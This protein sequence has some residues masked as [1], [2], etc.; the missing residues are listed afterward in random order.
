MEKHLEASRK[1]LSFLKKKFEECQDTLTV[2]MI[3]WDKHRV[4]L[5]DLGEKVI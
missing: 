1:L 2:V 3:D 4:Y 5:V